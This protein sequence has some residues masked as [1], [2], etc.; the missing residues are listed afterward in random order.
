MSRGINTDQAQHLQ[1]I[2]VS[3]PA[4]AS[5]LAQHRHQPVSRAQ[6]A[7]KDEFGRSVF[8][9][10]G[11]RRAQRREAQRRYSLL[12]VEDLIFFVAEK[13]SLLCPEV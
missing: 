9:Q 11:I 6:H 2:N 3:P 7:A 4:A 1:F 12:L 8:Q 5:T 13:T 10:S